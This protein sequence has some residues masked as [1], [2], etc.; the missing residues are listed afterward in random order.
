M[1]HFEQVEDTE[2]LR[3]SWNVWP[4]SKIDAA[5]L[6]VPLAALY[7][8]LKPRA[9][10]PVPYEPVVCR[11]PCKGV[12]NPY[13]QIDPRAK[14][15]VCPFCLQRNSFPPHYH[16]IGPHNLPPE[17][18]PASTTIEY[19]L[20][21]P[22]QT[23][24]IFL[25]VVDTCLD[26]QDLQALKNTLLGALAVIPAHALVGLVTFGTMVQVHELA[27]EACNKAYV[28][29][30]SK[31]YSGKQVQEML[32]LA[33]SP[34]ASAA[35][36][37]SGSTATSPAAQVRA[38]NAAGAAM[39]FLLP[40]G[41]CEFT[42]TSIIESLQRDPWPVGAD[43][44][45]ARATGVAS[46]VAISLLESA[47]PQAGARIFMFLGGACTQGPGM[48]VSTEL[49]D[50]I[51]SHHDIEKDNAK[52]HKRAFKYFEQLA[53]RAAANAHAVD[54][55]VGSYDQVGLHEM[56]HLP[57]STGGVMVL[58]DSF[59]T[60]IF[61]QSFLKMFVRDAQDQLGMAFNATMDVVTSKELKVA[62]LI[63]DSYSLGKKGANVAETEIGLGGTS[64]W[65]FAAMTPR[66]TAAVYFELANA[67]QTGP[68]APGSRGLVQFITH[69]QHA[70]GQMRLRVTT[71]ARHIVDGSAPDITASFDQEAAA[72]LMARIAVYKAELDDAPDVLRWLDR[73]LIRL[74]SRV[75]QYRKDDPNS[76]ALEDNFSI[77]PQFMFHLRRSQFLTVF[78][79][80]PDETAFYRH[81]FN[82]EDCNN[83]LIMI[84]PPLMSYEFNGDPKPVLLDSVSVK[85]DV[86][87]L[88]DT[89]FHILIHHGSTIAEWR[90]AK[91]HEQPE[92]ANFKQ[93]L[94]SPVA[95]ARSLLADRFPVPRYIDCDQNSSQA[96]FLLAKLNPS[97]TYMSAGGAGG[98]GGYGMGPQGGQGQ[99]IFTDDVSLQVFMDHLKRLAVSGNA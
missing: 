45:P 49:K 4:A 67:Q 77:Y 34:A 86:I 30:G 3:L 16:D 54:L 64:S 81:V 47:F 92:Y 98:L 60:H 44:R 69:Y 46:Q 38:P 55:F 14:L 22:A 88:L 89:F 35:A 43:K 36:G 73:M 21:R 5:K 9:Q 66:T 31:E 41:Q 79:N 75:A 96:R 63:G 99:A 10:D 37:G 58:S 82:L 48:V 11:P 15:W 74:C 1:S 17:L 18:L 50:P 24:P 57:G 97:T 76:F 33:V 83:S 8:P 51:R 13:C 6:V 26:D 27:S 87:L 85:P 53:S 29:R 62:G 80:S 25:F 2:G 23:P 42:L 19:I 52:Y 39:R 93:L 59:N 71:V 32:G 94:E 28:F 7:T 70:S 40:L 68:V 12:L 72:V 90:A 20:S 56:R 84:Q 61:K 65:R 91:Y 78:N 95:D